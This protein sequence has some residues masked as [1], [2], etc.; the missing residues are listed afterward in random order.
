MALVKEPRIAAQIPRIASMA[1]CFDQQLAEWNIKCAPVAAAIVFNSDLLPG[2]G[3][4]ERPARHLHDSEVGRGKGVVAGQG[5]E[6]L[7][8]A[9]TRGN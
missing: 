6:P 2:E 8:H 3:R 5:V 9:H 7:G 4:S 1:A